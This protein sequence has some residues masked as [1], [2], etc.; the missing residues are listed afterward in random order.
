M[1]TGLDGIGLLER[2]REKY[3]SLPFVVVTAVHDESVAEAAIS[4]GACDYLL[5]PFER[6]QLLATVRGA[7][8]THDERAGSREQRLTRIL[9]EV[10][11]S[12]QRW[13]AQARQITPETPK[14]RYKWSRLP[15]LLARVLFNFVEDAAEAAAV[16]AKDLGDLFKTIIGAVITAVIGGGAILLWLV[17]VGLLLVVG[18]PS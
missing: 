9:G 13:E 10:K 7:L 17:V 16:A 5:K 2:V 11:A 12:R 8:E 1:M 14:V 3:Q 6:E 15:R 18:L 4:R